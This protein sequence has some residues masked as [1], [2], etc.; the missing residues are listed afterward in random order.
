MTQS[1]HFFLFSIKNCQ[2]AYLN[3]S[4]AAPINGVLKLLRYGN[5]WKG[6]LPKWR[7]VSRFMGL[8]CDADLSTHSIETA[9]S[10]KV[11]VFNQQQ[12][13]LLPN[14]C[15]LFL[16][17]IWLLVC[18]EK[19]KIII[20]IIKNLWEIN[21]FSISSDFWKLAML[22][23]SQSCGLTTHRSVLAWGDVLFW[24]QFAA[25]ILP[26]PQIQPC[27]SSCTR[28][29][30]GSGAS[31]RGSRAGS[32]IS[33][34]IGLMVPCMGDIGKRGTHLMF[35]PLFTTCDSCCLTPKE[36]SCAWPSVVLALSIP[37]QVDSTKATSVL[38]V[39]PG[40][41]GGLPRRPRALLMEPSITLWPWTWMSLW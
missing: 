21:T 2:R 10:L 1:Y 11:L 31:W 40:W 29:G 4:L 5:G 36:E 23:W 7:F 39:A 32:N 41:P 8:Q 24:G 34:K 3:S 16:P 17:K 15:L 28:M 27:Q 13:V 12:V 30:L 26:A 37:V 33:P 35:T 14:K 20:I 18:I 9:A 22:T 25:E 38:C 19:F 6:G